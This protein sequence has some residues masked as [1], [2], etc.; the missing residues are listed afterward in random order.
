LDALENTAW[1]EDTGTIQIDRQE[2]QNYIRNYEGISA[3]LGWLACTNSGNCRST[4]ASIY[5]LNESGE[6]DPAE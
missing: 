4:P 3:A 6:Y 2:V 5:R 1:R